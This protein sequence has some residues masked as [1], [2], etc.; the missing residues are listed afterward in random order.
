MKKIL[1][2]LFFLLCS[3]AALAGTFYVSPTGGGT[4]CSAGSPCALSRIGVAGVAQPGDIWRL[5]NGTYSSGVTMDC[6]AGVNN[7]AP[8]NEI[9]VTADNERQAVL[10][11]GGHRGILFLSCSYW[12]V[13]G[14]RINQ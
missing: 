4:T 11:T 13:E 8:G 7:G 6:S 5:Q 2:A 12:R 14:I 10:S 9:L 1:L 3:T